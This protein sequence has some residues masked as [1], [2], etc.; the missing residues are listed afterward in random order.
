MKGRDNM[1]T[2]RELIFIKESLKDELRALKNWFRKYEP[3][4][5]TT[6]LFGEYEILIEKVEKML[7]NIN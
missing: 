7:D 6:K 4:R 5:D 1:F 3:K 2:E